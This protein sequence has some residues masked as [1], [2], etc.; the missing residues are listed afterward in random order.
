MSFKCIYFKYPWVKVFSL[1]WFKH[2]EVNQRVDQIENL[3]LGL[4]FKK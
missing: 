3:N 1:F 4:K 2:F